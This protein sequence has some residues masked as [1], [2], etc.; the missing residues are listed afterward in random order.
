MVHLG[1]LD[2]A[3]K[4]L[5]DSHYFDAAAAVLDD[6]ARSARMVAAMA[7]ACYPATVLPKDTATLIEDECRRRHHPHVEV[8]ANGGRMFVMPRWFWPKAKRSLH[9]SLDAGGQPTMIRKIGVGPARIPLHVQ[10]DRYRAAR[11]RRW[12]ERLLLD[13]TRVLNHAPTAASN[14]L[15]AAVANPEEAELAAMAVWNEFVETQELPLSPLDWP[16]TLGDVDTLC[17]TPE[18]RNF[19][20]HWTWAAYAMARTKANERR[21]CLRR[22]DDNAAN[23][24]GVA[25]QMLCCQG[26]EECEKTKALAKQMPRLGPAVPLSVLGVDDPHSNDGRAFRALLFEADGP[27]F[28]LPA[29]LMK[30]SPQLVRHQVQFA[31]EVTRAFE[32]GASSRYAVGGLIA[33]MLVGTDLAP[34][35]LGPPN[36]VAWAFQ[37]TSA[38]CIATFVGDIA[39]L[40]L[41]NDED[42]LGAGIVALA[43][44]FLEERL[45]VR[46][47]ID[48]S[49]AVA[50]TDGGVFE[51]ERAGTW[52]VP[53]GW[54]AHDASDGAVT[55][56]LSIGD[57][58]TEGAEMNNCLARGY[59]HDRA[60]AGEVHI[61]K[62][63][64]PA[65]RATL[66]LEEHRDAYSLRVVEYSILELKGS[67]NAEPRREAKRRAERLL[68]DLNASLPAE[69]PA[70]ER[71]RRSESARWFCADRA[72]AARAW[73]TRYS[74]ALPKRLRTSS[75]EQVVTAMRRD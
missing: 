23:A 34:E 8:H 41:A 36:A 52:P 54:H 39:H 15:H 12:A 22:L 51:S 24:A 9:I 44:F 33:R 62:L 75:P 30:S 61:F 46:Q 53:C 10:P 18:R 59:Y 14:W 73:R 66:A 20:T 45:T 65:G 13:L 68:T 21:Q 1:P 29:R 35:K 5:D 57:I 27:G 37:R 32:R 38:D 55:P 70:D 2:G 3:R 11:C 6:D 60:A 72:R 28:P 7:M 49:A 69:I 64:L 40:G 50:P 63:R 71:K 25:V 19:A 17:G 42:R 47:L 56:L 67:R 4:E 74:I 16:L 26:V 43:H 31:L 48:W 58:A